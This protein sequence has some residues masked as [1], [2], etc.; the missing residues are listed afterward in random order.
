VQST[1]THPILLVD[2][3]EIFRKGVRYVLDDSG[4]VDVVGEADTVEHALA[5]IQDAPP[6]VAVIG[7]REH[8]RDRLALL[9]PLRRTHP[10]LKVLVLTRTDDDETLTSAL[11]AG[12]SGYLSK[13]VSSQRLISSVVAVARGH[14]LID[15]AR[16]LRLMRASQ[17]PP[18]E[19]PEDPLRTLTN[20]ERRILAL[21]AEGLSNREIAQQLFLVEKT[22][23]NHVTR[24]LAKLGV[25]RRTQ[26]ALIAARLTHGGSRSRAE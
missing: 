23:R 6:D 25:E 22:V 2:S 4:D 16:A 8:E 9:R 10:D 24:V 7:V 1:R 14:N 11:L 19:P 17:A 26:A 3:H 12:A 21:L 13:D 5:A 18:T 15:P 20:Q